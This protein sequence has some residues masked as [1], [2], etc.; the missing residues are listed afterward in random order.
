MRCLRHDSYDIIGDA[1]GLAG[2][3][4]MVVQ[5]SYGDLTRSATLEVVR[6]PAQRWY[7]RGRR[8]QSRSRTSACDSVIMHSHLND[9]SPL[10]LRQLHQN[11]CLVNS[12]STPD[13]AAGVE[14]RSASPRLRCVAARR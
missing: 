11:A 6:G 14:R 13:V 5:V 9:S 4:A 3:R 1:P 12:T 10:V 2:A 7:V 8:H